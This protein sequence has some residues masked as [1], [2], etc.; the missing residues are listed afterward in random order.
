MRKNKTKINRL[1]ISCLCVHFKIAMRIVNDDFDIKKL[2]SIKQHIQQQI[3]KYPELSKYAGKLSQFIGEINDENT[4]T[5]DTSVKPNAK[6]LISASAY[7][8]PQRTKNKKN[9]SKQM[10]HISMSPAS[11]I[12]PRS[13]KLRTQTTKLQVPRFSLS[14]INFAKNLDEG[15]LLVLVCVCVCVCACVCISFLFFFAFN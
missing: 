10:N 7:T 6:Q 15:M 13:E 5:N 4:L 1:F 8:S 2:D 9:I 3:R 11:E 14:A 12:L